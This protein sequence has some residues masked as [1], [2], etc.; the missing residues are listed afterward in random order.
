MVTMPLSPCWKVRIVI[1]SAA[2]ESVSLPKALIVT[3]PLSLTDAVAK[4]GSNVQMHSGI[5]EADSSDLSGIPAAAKVA[6][7]ADKV[8]MALGVD[9]SW[10]HEVG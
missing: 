5:P 6:A 8:V 9:L 7:A 2:S 10:A 3:V 1:L 4:Y